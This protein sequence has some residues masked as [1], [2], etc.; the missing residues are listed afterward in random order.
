MCEGSSESESEG[1]KDLDLQLWQEEFP[2]K[3]YG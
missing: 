3:Q 1:D 2:K